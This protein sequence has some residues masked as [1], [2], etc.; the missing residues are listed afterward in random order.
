MGRR[1][2]TALM[3]KLKW[4]DPKLAPM[5]ATDHSAGADVKA[6]RDYV[7]NPN[8]VAMIPT[9]LWIDQSSIPNWFA[10]SMPELQVRL[11]S[12]MSTKYGLIMPNGIGTIDIDY[13]DEIKVLIYNPG[14]KPHG[15]LQGDR[16]A[17]L[18][19]NYIVHF[20][21]VPVGGKR[22]GGFGS[23]GRN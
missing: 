15:V 23:T 1:G 17:Q 18:V 11:R 13:P 16:I 20:N 21:G 14:S 22:T 10:I 12:S 6:A 9:G 19:L 4:K 7:I 2:R 3:I 8:T 5:Y